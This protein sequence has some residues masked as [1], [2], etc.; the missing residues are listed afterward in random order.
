[1]DEPTTFDFDGKEYTPN[2][3]GEKF[4]GKVTLREAL[5]DSLN[6]ATVKVAELVGYTRV[7]DMAHQFGLDPSI[8]P[9]PSVALG[10][11]E[12]TPLEVA[13]GYTIFANEGVR[14]EPMF[15]R[16]VVNADGESL[17]TKRH[18]HAAGARS[19]RRLPGDQH[20]GGRDQPRHRRDRARS[21]IHRAGG[22]K[23]R[24]FPRRLV[25]RLHLEPAGHRLGG[26]RRQSRP[27]PFRRER[28]RAHLGGIHEAR[29]HVARVP[30]RPAV[31]NAGRRHASHHRSRNPATGHSR[32]PDH[33][34]GSLHSR[35]RA[36]RILR[37]AWR[38][39]GQRCAAGF[40]ALAN[41]WRRQSQRAPTCLSRPR[42]EAAAGRRKNSGAAPPAS[43]DSQQPE[44]ENKKGVLRR[45]FGIFGGKKDADKPQQETQD[46]QR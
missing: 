28:S 26:I 34:R 22:G 30:R 25:R 46:P 1:M 12:M 38:A 41:F 4:H 31:R 2:N 13:A 19:A 39:H 32:V 27:G 21:R 42:R 43:A 20:D 11:Y 35:H 3:Y 23:D 24:H 7:T 5:T 6:V 37:L 17:G 33:S 18:P 29:D 40:L 36:D 15:I 9:T 8:Q 14:A 45:I 44:E 16:N 10:A